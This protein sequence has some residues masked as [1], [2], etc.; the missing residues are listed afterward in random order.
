MNTQTSKLEK[1][2]DILT[3][4]V[5][6]IEDGIRRNDAHISFITRI[7]FVF[8]DPMIKM[9]NFVKGFNF[10]RNEPILQIENESMY[11]EL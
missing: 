8:R 2:I 11:N 4:K 9:A 6:N 3:H 1:K 7:Y 10:I 5:S